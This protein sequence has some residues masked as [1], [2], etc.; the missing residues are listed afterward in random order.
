MGGIADDVALDLGAALA[1]QEHAFAFGLHALGDHRDIESLAEAYHGAHA[2]LG[3]AVMVDTRDERPIDLDLVEGEIQ[4]T[5]SRCRSARRAPG[6][7][8]ETLPRMPPRA[9]C[10]ALTLCVSPGVNHTFTNAGRSG[11]IMV[12]ETE[13]RFALA[14]KAKWTSFLPINIADGMRRRGGVGS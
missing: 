5:N 1:L 8:D 10:Q 3:L 9:E 13:I 14:K 6:C 4:P 11:A 7:R 12:N 2:R